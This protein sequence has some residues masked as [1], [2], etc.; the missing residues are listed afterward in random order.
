MQIS[1]AGH[2][3]AA[4]RQAETACPEWTDILRA[5]RIAAQDYCQ[6]VMNLTSGDVAGFNQAW[7]Q[8]ERARKACEDYRAM[9]HYHEHDHRCFRPRANC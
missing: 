5:Y 1:T 6:A 7:L 8:A 2:F 3:A 4:P 9:L